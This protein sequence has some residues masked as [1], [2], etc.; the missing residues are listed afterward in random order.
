MTIPVPR[1]PTVEWKVKAA[2][3]GAYLAG[4]VGMAILQAV[5]DGSLLASLPEPYATL[6]AP[7]VPALVAFVSGYL[8]QHTPRSSG[9]GD[10]VDALVTRRAQEAVQ[11]GMADL[12]E[13]LRDVLG[14]RAT[15]QLKVGVSLTGD[16]SAEAAERAA[17]RH[18]VDG[19]AL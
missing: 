12:A 13:K 10:D 18:A 1:V 5:A 11:A 9:L 15:E 7:L 6:L 19:G 4:V 17:A 2:S 8:T 14:P 16:V 3:V